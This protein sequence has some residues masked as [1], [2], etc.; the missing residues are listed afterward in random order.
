[1]YEGYEFIFY[2]QIEDI[3]SGDKWILNYKNENEDNISTKTCEFII[4]DFTEIKNEIYRNWYK[5]YVW[6]DNTSIYSKVHMKSNIKEFFNYISDLK[7]GKQLSI[8]SKPTSDINIYQNEILAYIHTNNENVI[9]EAIE[10]IQN[11]CKI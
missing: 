10:K 2:N 9:N 1:M 6:K 8:Y 4:I 3:P 7:E 11:I 5:C